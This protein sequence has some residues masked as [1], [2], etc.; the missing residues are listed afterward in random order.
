MFTYRVKNTLTV[1]MQPHY[2]TLQI[3]QVWLPRNY[4]GKF[5]FCV[6]NLYAFKMLSIKQFL[7]FTFRMPVH[8]FS[9]PFIK[10]PIAEISVL[11]LGFILCIR[12]DF[13]F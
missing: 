1:L 6:F 4:S 9:Y 2:V 12:Q 13:T 5:I 11:F 3:L 7:K 10:N 8:F